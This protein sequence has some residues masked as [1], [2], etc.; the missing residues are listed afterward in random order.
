[1]PGFPYTSS[2]ALIGTNVVMLSMPFIRGQG[3][4]LAAGVVM[5]VLFS[6]IYLTMKF[7]S[8]SKG[9]DTSYKSIDFKRF[10][11]RLASEFSRE[12][13]IDADKKKN[14]KNSGK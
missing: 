14:N 7:F 1:M 2:L 11:G 4:W 9:K 12:L 6:L 8:S 5:L 3:A 13:T 10:H